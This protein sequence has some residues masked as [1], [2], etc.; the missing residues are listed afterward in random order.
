MTIEQLQVLQLAGTVSIP[1]SAT[2]GA[3]RMRVSMKYNGILLLVK[4]S[5]MGK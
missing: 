5:L 1:T 4:L 3:T 2:I